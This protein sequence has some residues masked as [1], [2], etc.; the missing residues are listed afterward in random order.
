MHTDTAGLLS[1]TAEK[2]SLTSDCL[3][4]CHPPHSPHASLSWEACAGFLGWKF[5]PP[6]TPPD[7]LQRFS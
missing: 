1:L 3:R 2:K 4:N 7:F 6:G 5:L